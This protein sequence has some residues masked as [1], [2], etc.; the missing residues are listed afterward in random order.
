MQDVLSQTPLMIFFW[1][2]FRRPG[3]CFMQTGCIYPFP[4]YVVMLLSL[5]K[6]TTALGE[7]SR[8]HLATHKAM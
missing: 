1:A 3:P 7:H 2:S 6:T 4:V 8:L 5:P